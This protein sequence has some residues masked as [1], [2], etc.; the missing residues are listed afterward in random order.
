MVNKIDY[1]TMYST[2]ENLKDVGVI[3][4]HLSDLCDVT[5]TQS[6]SS[7][8]VFCEFYTSSK[9]Y[10]SKCI[11][12]HYL[13]GKKML[14]IISVPN[15]ELQSKLLQLDEVL[16]QSMFSELD[17]VI[18]SNEELINCILKTLDSMMPRIKKIKVVSSLP[19]SQLEQVYWFAKCIKINSYD[20]TDEILSTYPHLSNEGQE[21]SDHDINEFIN[22]YS[23]MS[24]I[25]SGLELNEDNCYLVSLLVKKLLG[26]C[27]DE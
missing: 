6:F 21:F 17:F 11:T 7:T 15:I 8:G 3:P 1:R 16:G 27:I 12:L 24:F 26:G 19:Q 2:L 10:L 23:K 9:E 4:T 22:S 13:T 20:C 25:D 5:C 18:K 14:E